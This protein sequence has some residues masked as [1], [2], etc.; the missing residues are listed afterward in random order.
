MELARIFSNL[1]TLTHGQVICLIY[2]EYQVN[3]IFIE[4]IEEQNPVLWEVDVPLDSLSPINKP[5]Y[6]VNE[7]GEME[8]N[9]DLVFLKGVCVEYKKTKNMWN[10]DP[11]SLEALGGG[12]NVS[13]EALQN[14]DKRNK[15]A[16]KLYEFAQCVDE[17]VRVLEI[18]V[19]KV[20]N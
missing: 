19:D 1:L 16:A 14:K 18:N 3:K 12:F 10:G 2:T 9:P 20:T 6:R 15:I 13:L 7:Q 5:H 8:L 4:K 17:I 11:D